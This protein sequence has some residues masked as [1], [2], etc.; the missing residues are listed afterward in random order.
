MHNA[1][2]SETPITRATSEDNDMTDKQHITAAMLAEEERMQQD[3]D[4]DLDKMRV[5]VSCHLL[6]SYP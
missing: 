6:V 2:E 5:D 3:T 1:A 4:K